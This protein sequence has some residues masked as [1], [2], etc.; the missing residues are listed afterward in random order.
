MTMIEST[1]TKSALIFVA[2][3]KVTKRQPSVVVQTEGVH[4]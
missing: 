3:L 1:V 2:E 4:D